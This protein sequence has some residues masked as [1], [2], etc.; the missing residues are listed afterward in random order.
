MNKNCRTQHF[1]FWIKYGNLLHNCFIFIS[2]MPHNGFIYE[3]SMDMMENSGHW[4]RAQFAST[5]TAQVTI[6]ITVCCHCSALGTPA[7]APGSW[8]GR[9][10]VKISDVQLNCH[11]PDTRYWPLGWPWLSWPLVTIPCIIA[12]AWARHLCPSWHDAIRVS[13]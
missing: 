8:T 5:T 12:C 7:V 10:R 2:K 11:Q 1:I 13:T 6:I 4:F 9:H 3:A